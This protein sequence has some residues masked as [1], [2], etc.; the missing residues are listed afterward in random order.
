M[1]SITYIIN[2][3]YGIS[4]RI[5]RKKHAKLL[6]LER[7][8]YEKEVKKV[9]RFMYAGKLIIHKDKSLSFIGEDSHVFI[10]NN[11]IDEKGELIYKFRS[12]KRFYANNTLL[13]T[14]K[15]FPEDV[16]V[17][18][19]ENTL[20]EEVCLD[21]VGTSIHFRDTKLKKLRIKK[22][23]FNGEYNEDGYYGLSTVGD[24]SH[25]DTFAYIP[26]LSY[27]YLAENF[28]HF[29][30]A[31]E[32]TREYIEKSPKTSIFIEYYFL[33][34]IKDVTLLKIDHVS[35][36]NHYFSALYNMILKDKKI[37]GLYDHYKNYINNISWPEN[38]FNDNMKESHQKISK[39]NL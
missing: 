10:H 2:Y 37:Y 34:T 19:I 7:K 1:R 32:K 23:K 3:F 29:I 33:T 12:A 13:K 14:C 17:L 20:I 38:F 24:I 4:V 22:V 16:E 18:M 28:N 6:A 5:T 31:G 9:F 21:Y 25:L 15:N 35:N 30:N 36:P 8:N 11:M 27:P 26:T 39:F